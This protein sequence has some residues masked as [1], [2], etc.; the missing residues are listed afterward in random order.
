MRTRGI[1]LA[2]RP[3]PGAVCLVDVGTVAAEVREAR[4]PTAEGG[5]FQLECLLRAGRFANET[6]G[7]VLVT[8][9]TSKAAVEL[10]GVRFTGQTEALAALAGLEPDDVTMMFLGPRLNVA[11]VTTHH[12]VVD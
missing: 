1:R 5:R 4:A 12:A 9:P 10:S 8:G 6:E 2:A 7:A 3:E 11:L